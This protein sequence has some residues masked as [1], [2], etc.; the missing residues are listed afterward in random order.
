MR[1][2]NANESMTMVRVSA[3]LGGVLW[4]FAALWG[5][6]VISS[7]FVRWDY[8]GVYVFLLVIMLALA[9]NFILFRRAAVLQ[10]TTLIGLVAVSLFLSTLVV[11]SIVYMAAE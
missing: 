7:E 3:G 11:G 2:M 5:L 8:A 1:W 6:A 10:T 4:G 9:T